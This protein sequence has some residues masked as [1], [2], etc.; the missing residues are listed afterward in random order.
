VLLNHIDVPVS[1]VFMPTTPNPTSGVLI[2][3]PDEDL[4]HLRMSVEDAMK[5]VISAGSV[6]PVEIDKFLDKLQS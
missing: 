4:I 2:F 3:V 5:L 6:T 1:S